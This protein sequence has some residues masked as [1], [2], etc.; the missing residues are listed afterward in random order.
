MKAILI[1]FLIATF[2]LFAFIFTFVL[3]SVA[4]SG[5]K[6][7]GVE[8]GIIIGVGM[9]LIFFYYVRGEFVFR[10]SSL[11]IILNAALSGLEYYSVTLFFDKM[12]KSDIPYGM[13][14]LLITIPICIVINK[15]M[16][17]TISKKTK[18]E[19]REKKAFQF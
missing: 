1:D 10:I 16:L 5:D 12:V 3:L 4:F 6:E 17:D 15:L 8:F 7:S 2:S 11:H 19:K 9:T 14:L 13:I 18:G